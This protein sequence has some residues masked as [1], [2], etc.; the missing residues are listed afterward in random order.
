MAAS[1]AGAGR[2]NA[3]AIAAVRGR[4]DARASGSGNH[5]GDASCC[6]SSAGVRSP[7]R[8]SA[9]PA[10][11]QAQ[12]SYPD[13]PVRFIIAFPPGGATDTFFRVISPELATALGGSIVIEN[14]ARRRR[15]HRLA[16][17]RALAG[18]RL[19]RAG[20]GK[21]T[22]H[23]PGAVQETS[24]GL[25]PAQGLR[26]GRRDGEH[27]A[28]VDRR[29]Q[30]PANNFKEFVAWS[31]TVKDNSPTVTPVPA[32]CRILCPR[33]FSTAPACRPFP[34]RS[35]AAGRPRRRSPA[36]TSPW[37]RRR[38]RSPRP[39]REASSSRTFS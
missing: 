39:R 9:L 31:K 3:T 2:R 37:S 6:S 38:S 10:L 5:S 36:V 32:A 14:K 15:L 28:G 25:Q 8:C 24:V 17:G 33:S 27:A 35:R 4:H 12:A 22:R 1:S 34:C 16:R 7:A 18:R 30:R 19:H 23:Q 13:R 20:G 26:R 11:A 21:C 29:Q